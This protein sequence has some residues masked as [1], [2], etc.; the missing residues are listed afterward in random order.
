LKIET[1]SIGH[2]H[3][4][5]VIIDDFA[6]DPAALVDDAAM[7]SFDLQGEYYPGV[8]AIVHPALAAKF[9]AQIE[10]VL[11]ETFDIAPPFDHLDCWYSLVTTPPERLT[12]IQRLPHFDST[13]R[14]RIALLHYLA[15]QGCGGTSFFRHRSTG[16]NAVSEDRLA[17][18]EA[19]L[20][21]DI[22]TNGM[23][24]AAY[25]S[26][27]TP[28]FEEIFRVEGRFNRAVLYRGNTLHCAHIPEGLSFSTD[29]RV[30]R[31]TVNSFIHGRCV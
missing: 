27:N 18:Y 17:A 8:R 15:P 19:A 11:D 12:P 30:G 23:P 25:I 3:T 1:L 9:V 2:E 5:I 13:D 4:Q 26:G 7:L 28:I 31:L 20:R 16:F 22:A 10:T 24:D 29:P 21:S 6:D 14:G